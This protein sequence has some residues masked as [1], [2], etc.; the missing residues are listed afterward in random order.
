MAPSGVSDP[1]RMAP[2]VR[3]EMTSCTRAMAPHRAP[4]TSVPSP[5]GTNGRFHV[6]AG[7]P[8]SVTVVDNAGE[9]SD[10][11]ELGISP[12]ADP[13]DYYDNIGISDDTDTN[14]RVQAV[15]TYLETLS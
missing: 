1:K 2:L 12:S 4:S 15:L 7:T 14:R 5:S 11:P 9:V 3:S 10:S 8:A 13:A 6:W